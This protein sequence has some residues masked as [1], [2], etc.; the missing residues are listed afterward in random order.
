L[1]DA[2][3]ALAPPGTNKT[4]GQGLHRAGSNLT[5]AHA[6]DVALVIDARALGTDGL[7]NAGFRSLTRIY[8]TIPPSA[9]P[10]DPIWVMVQMASS[11]K[12]IG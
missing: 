9:D 10:R 3:R 12:I 11:H 4:C 6:G 8:L 7:A 1:A 5:T 2:C